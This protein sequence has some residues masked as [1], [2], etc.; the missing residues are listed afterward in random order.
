MV[1]DAFMINSKI[2]QEELR[3]LAVKKK[4]V[5]SLDSLQKVVNVT[6]A[7]HKMKLLQNI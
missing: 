7:K 1:A 4:K 6:R 3:K 5:T 2:L